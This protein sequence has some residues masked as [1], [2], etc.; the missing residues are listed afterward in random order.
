MLT[1]LMLR[2]ALVALLADK[3]SDLLSTYSIGVCCLLYKRTYLCPAT[4]MSNT[5][6]ITLLSVNQEEH[7]ECNLGERNSAKG[8]YVPLTPYMSAFEVTHVIVLQVAHSSSCTF[9][10]MLANSTLDICAE[11]MIL[12]QVCG[13]PAVARCIPGTRSCHSYQSVKA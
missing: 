10:Y 11:C 1:A 13:V 5:A 2:C 8:T 3:E 4:C 6:T 12:H 7:V 9:A